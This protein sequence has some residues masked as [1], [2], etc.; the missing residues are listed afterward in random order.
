[1]AAGDSPGKTCRILEGRGTARCSPNS[2]DVFQPLETGHVR[3]ISTSKRLGERTDN[4]VL[5][6]NPLRLHRQDKIIINHF[7]CA[8]PQIPNIYLFQVAF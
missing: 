4:S 1:M 2:L 8:G 3:E 6:Q 5:N 7:Q